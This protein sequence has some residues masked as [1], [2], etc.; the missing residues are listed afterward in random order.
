[1]LT[2]PLTRNPSDAC[3]FASSCGFGI[4]ERFEASAAAGFF[5]ATAE[6][7]VSGELGASFVRAI[8][9]LRS[10]NVNSNF[11]AGVFGVMVTSAASV[12][13]PCISISTLA[14]P[15]TR[16]VKVNRPPWSE[17]VVTLF[18]PCVTVTVAPGTGQPWKVTWP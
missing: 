8:I 9:W 5:V 15:S 1:M 10:S 4:S 2:L 16:S 13:K 3:S 12:E 6:L 14:G 18:F 7:T 17:T 11:P